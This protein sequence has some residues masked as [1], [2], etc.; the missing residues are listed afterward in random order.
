MGFQLKTKQVNKFMVKT[1]LIIFSLIAF[2]ALSQS[3]KHEMRGLWICTAYNL[4]WPSTANLDSAQ[5]KKELIEI[6][7]NAQ[8]LHLN[9]IY[10]QVRSAGDA[11]YKSKTEPWSHWLT[12]KQ[13]KAPLYDPLEFIIKEC[14]KRNMEL[15]AWFNLFRAVSH[16]KFS[17]PTKTHFAYEHPD[18]V[19]LAEKKK[20]LDP[21]VPAARKYSVEVINEV[22]ENYDIDG[23]HLDDYFYYQEK[24]GYKIPDFTT[25]KKYG[26]GFNNIKNW[27]R[28]NLDLLIS[29][30]YTNIKSRKPYVKF[31]IS[32]IP[33][34]RH[35]HQDTK[36]SDTKIATS[37]YDEYYADTHKWYTKGWVDYML[38]Q[39]YWG[40]KHPYVGYNK[41]VGWWN[42]IG[43]GRHVY[44]G[45]AIYKVGNDNRAGWKSTQEI[46]QQIKYN[47]T[48]TNIL[49]QG[50]YRAKNLTNAKFNLIDEIKKN[51][52]KHLSIPPP[53]PW[54]DSIPA[55][56]PLML[57]YTTHNDTH[58]LTWPSSK[59]A[60][61][62]QKATYYILYEFSPDKELNLKQASN[63]IG[64]TSQN[65]LNISAKNQDKIYIIT[66]SDRLHNESMKFSGI[67]VPGK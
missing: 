15:H 44:I 54:L 7:D 62:R 46:H 4:D 38:P 1:L 55:E 29:D 23:V 66:A 37:C 39:A 63:I 14:H 47:R 50:F 36:G 34:W 31:G 21:G 67:Y 42:K 48:A 16:H 18:W 13:G 52:Y 6:L 57:N 27:R 30:I 61:D 17:P 49:G 45:Q 41:T 51:E 25:F 26:Q 56:A 53:M 22:I 20:M 35:K 11:Y 33:V 10:F 12:G 58:T 60:K 64:I 8:S 43:T 19:Y 24:D 2:S 9:T 59:I 32:P 65:S 5:Q 28:N 3:P 40:I